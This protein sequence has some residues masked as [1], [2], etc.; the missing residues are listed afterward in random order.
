MMK[1]IELDVVQ[2]RAVVRVLEAAEAAGLKD[3]AIS[4][5]FTEELTVGRYEVR[6]RDNVSDALHGSYG[7]QFSDPM[8]H[9]LPLLEEQEKTF[10]EMASKGLVRPI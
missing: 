3:P 6:S 2:A 9:L 4:M 5:R 7:G 1:R 10:Q 8:K